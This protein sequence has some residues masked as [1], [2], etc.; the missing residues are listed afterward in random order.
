MFTGQR[1]LIIKKIFYWLISLSLVLM[2]VTLSYIY[3]PVLKSPVAGYEAR[4]GQIKSATVTR[5]WDE[6]D[7]NY[8]EMELVSTSGLKVEITIRRPTK[9]KTKL[10]VAL[11]LGGVG[12]GRNA[13]QIIPSI[14]HVICVSLSYPYFGKKHLD[15][16]EFLLNIRK[17]QQT[18]KDTPPALMLT[19][20]YVLSQNFS[21]HE[22]VELLGVSFGSYFISIPAVLDKRVT[23]VW[24]AHGAAEPFRSMSHNYKKESRFKFFNNLL[25]Y[26]VG[27]AIGSEYVDPAKWVGRISP[28]PVIMINARNDA[29][30]P[31]SSVAA[32]HNA[33]RDP[34][35]IIWT[36]GLHV[37][38]S[39]KD[40][41]KLLTDIVLSRIEDDY[42][43]KHAH[44]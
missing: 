18:V 9:I 31:S 17:I 24:I 34:K 14:H 43:K 20:D 26:M 4:K 7:S 40:V 39:R 37:T 12:T 33:A 28:R 22:Q 35:E 19:L 10:P 32:L 11:L 27:Y 42:L 38:P 3:V 30:F 13:C 36:E 2:L 8:Q 15:D 21:D 41:V 6:E 29:T 25:A 23:R 1:Y 5:T 16:I 44:N